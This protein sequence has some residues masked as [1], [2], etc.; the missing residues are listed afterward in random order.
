MEKM[1]ETLRPSP[2][3]ILNPRCDPIFK[4]IF[5]QNTEYSNTALKS[6][7]SAAI[8]RSVVKVNLEPNEPAVDFPDQMQMSFDV[9]VLFDDG[10]IASIEMQGRNYK[11]DYGVRSE[12]QV[13]RLLNLVN[14]KGSNWNVPKVYQISVLNF[15]YDKDDNDIQSWYT[16]KSKAGNELG[17]RLNVIYLD[18]IKMRRK[19]G[20]PVEKLTELEKWGMYFAFADDVQQNEYVNKIIKSEKGLMA[21][22]FTVKYMSEED[23]NWFRQNSYD[24]AMRDYNSAM[25]AAV[26]SGLEEGRQKG[27]QEGI[28]EGIKEGIQKGIKEGIQEG[29][30]NKAFDVARKL[31]TEKIPMEI[32]AKCTGLEIKEIESMA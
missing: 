28:K 26:N 3:A 7:I 18:L 27:L 14:K 19:L 2:K 17:G 6:F 9:S 16:M 5:T 23:A 30:R 8:G 12:I 32:I 10:E 21:A 25:E 24:I 1:K 31:L 13:A 29:E 15:E 20:T 11:Y 22:D 4:A